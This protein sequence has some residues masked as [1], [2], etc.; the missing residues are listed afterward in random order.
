[1]RLPALRR[2][3]APAD[4]ARPG[5]DGWLA[6][7]LGNPGE[8]YVATRHNV[9][10]EVVHEVARR[11][12]ITVG[13]SKFDTLFG[14]GDTDG[15][16][17]WVAQ[18][19]KYMNECGPG[20]AALGRFYKIHAQH[21]I[22]VYDEL[23]LPTGTIR[24]RARGGSGGHR[25][26]GSLARALGTEDFPRVRVGIGRPPEGWDAADYV[27]GRFTDDE[28]AVIALAV[29]RAADAVLAI[30]AHGVDAAMNAFNG[31]S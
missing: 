4:R 7:G 23:D 1:V 21:T 11:L 6:A 18:S 30:L 17:L 14:R 19:L 10:R 25:G 20:F 24:V 31:G 29:E 16:R 5:D 26:V 27:L 12:R 8:R 3:A 9:G 13:Q 15:H 2:H 28:R 22:A